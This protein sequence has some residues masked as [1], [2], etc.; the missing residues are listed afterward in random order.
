M[1]QKTSDIYLLYEPVKIT[2]NLGCRV[3]AAILHLYTVCCCYLLLFKKKKKKN[4]SILCMNQMLVPGNGM[5]NRDQQLG[6]REGTMPITA[7]TGSTSERMFICN[8]IVF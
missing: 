4:R 1:S 3:I 6:A 8:C 2:G 5:D 7:R